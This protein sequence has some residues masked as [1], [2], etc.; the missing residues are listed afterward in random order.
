[1]TARLPEFVA[2]L[3]AVA[4]A[5]QPQDMVRPADPF[6]PAQRVQYYLHRTY[7]WQRMSLLVADTG[8]GHLLAAPDAWGRGTDRFARCYGSAFGRR[9]VSNSIELGAGMVLREDSRYR[10]SRGKSFT[11]R[12]RYAA[13]HSLLASVPGG[14]LR[15]AYS[16]VAA[17]AGTELIVAVWSPYPVSAASVLQGTAFTLLGAVENSYLSEFE[18]DLKQFARRLRD[19]LLRRRARE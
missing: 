7:D 11:G 5:A 19:R 14:N 6:T 4:G 15:P 13:V 10:P 8:L 18:P 16:R 3:L 17:A 9:V 2:L 1:M 12:L